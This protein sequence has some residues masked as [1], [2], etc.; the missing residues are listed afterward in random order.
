MEN[1]KI[2]QILKDMKVVVADE[3]YI[4]YDLEGFETNREEIPAI[5]YDNVF[6]IGCS[7]TNR[8][9]P[10]TKELTKIFYWGEVHAEASSFLNVLH[11]AG[12]RNVESQMEDYGLDPL[13]KDEP[14]WE[15]KITTSHFDEIRNRQ[16]L[17]SSKRKR[18]EEFLPRK[19][20]RV[21]QKEESW[22]PRSS[23]GHRPR[24]DIS[25]SLPSPYQTDG[26]K[27]I[28]YNPAAIDYGLDDKNSTSNENTREVFTESQYKMEEDEESSLVQQK[29]DGNLQNSSSD[30]TGPSQGLNMIPSNNFNPVDQNSKELVRSHVGNP[31]FI[32]PTGG[33]INPRDRPHQPVIRNGH[34]FDN[35]IRIPQGYVEEIDLANLASGFQWENGQNLELQERI[36]LCGIQGERL[37]YEVLK[38]EWQGSADVFWVNEKNESGLPYDICLHFNDSNTTVYVEVKSTTT[39]SKQFFRITRKEMEKA[40][41]SRDKYWIYRVFNVLNPEQASMSRLIDPIQLWEGKFVNMFMQI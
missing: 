4:V 28:T 27:V 24:P 23:V 2:I 14:R 34:S 7:A 1:N 31:S 18:I 37:C 5:Y 33:D 32:T 40:Q 3:V 10:I 6:A 13:P 30:I 17:E 26:Q 25:D 11:I 20:R 15:F 39:A 29:S 16:I 22:P 21:D 12:E 19:R 35:V 38:K 8:V 36:A 9:L 41:E